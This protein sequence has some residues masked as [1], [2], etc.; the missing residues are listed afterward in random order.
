[1]GSVLQ[2]STIL[3]FSLAQ[4]LS[5]QDKA[6]ALKSLNLFLEQFPKAGVIQRLRLD[7]AT[8]EAFKEIAHEYLTARITKG[9]PSLFVDVKALYGDSE[10]QQIFGELVEGYRSELE[11]SCKFTPTE[12]GL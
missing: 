7:L 5:E 10:K 6:S 9:V 2:S 4:D 1:M 3:I 12:G 8:K 11:K